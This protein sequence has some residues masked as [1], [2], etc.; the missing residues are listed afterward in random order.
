MG[1]KNKK[2]RRMR[3]THPRIRTVLFLLF[4]FIAVW[5]LASAHWAFTTWSNLQM[6][7]IIY[8]LTA[9]LTGTGNNMILEYILKCIVPGIVVVVIAA[10]LLFLIRKKYYYARV[11]ALGL[12]VSIFTSGGVGVYAY[13]ELDVGT[14]LENRGKDSTYIEDNYA[15]PAEVNMTFPETKRNLI[16]I[17]LESM[18]VTYADP[19]SGG[20]MPENYIPELTQLAQE[21]EDFSGSSDRLNGGYAMTGA[22]WTMGAMFAQTSGLPLQ[23]PL[24]TNG[25]SSQETFF[26]GITTMGDILSEQGYSQTLLLGSNA[27]FG[28]RRL[29]FTEHGG[30][31]MMDY[32]YAEENGLIP[33]GYKVWWGYEDEKLFD[34]AK[35][36]LTA[37][38]NET[39]PFNL[40]M[41]TVDTHFP[42]G[43]ECELCGDEFGDNQYAN[44][45]HCSSRQV[46]EFI[47]WCSQQSWY[48]NT[49]IVISG[50]HLTMDSDFCDDVDSDY[51]RKVYTT[52]INSAVEN[53][54]PEKRRKYTTFDNFPTTLAALGVTIDGDRL[55]LGTNLFSETET[56]S[57]RDGYAN[58]NIEMMRNSEFMRKAS[59]ISD[60]VVEAREQML[61][62]KV[63]VSAEVKGE[64][65]QF[66]VKG[67][68]DIKDLFSYAFIHCRNSNQLTLTEP[69][70]QQMDNGDFAIRVPKA[71][72]DGY[73]DITYML[74]LRTE[75]GTVDMT[76]AIP[77]TIEWKS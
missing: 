48:D 26:P 33:E 57:E 9:P 51:T 52:Y 53:P 31:D 55:G 16:Y 56:L 63:K 25:M 11:T 21:N 7:E 60:E 44:V 30:Y 40:T 62:T 14:Y 17:F 27:T 24:D 45:M 35:Q 42:D 75:D 38:G 12:I 39:Q 70:L 49:T 8:E 29:Y 47:D 23:I 37:L 19:S 4:L 13:N 32:S 2:Q 77:Y 20:G 28:G 6:S 73:T 34:F 74:R 15:D 46:S 58:E 66:T 3:H 65:L 36:K 72:F 50:D 67:L 5:L 10:V 18:E 76:D 43:Y 68:D 59:N 54:Q 69:I 1:E 41:L 71:K 22:T 61:N 64:Y